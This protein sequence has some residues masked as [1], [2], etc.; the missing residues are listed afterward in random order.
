MRSTCSSAKRV[1]WSVDG[2]N[3]NP[4]PRSEFASCPGTVNTLPAASQQQHPSAESG[5]TALSEQPCALGSHAPGQ[6]ADAACLDSLVPC[7]Q[8]GLRHRLTEPGSRSINSTEPHVGHI[9][10][11]G[12]MPGRQQPRPSAALTAAAV[13]SAPA[14]LILSLLSLDNSVPSIDIRVFGSQQPTFHS[15]ASRASHNTTMPAAHVAVPAIAAAAAAAVAI[16]E[17]PWTQ[18]TARALRR[19]Q[20]EVKE[21]FAAQGLPPSAEKPMCFDLVGTRAAG[22]GSAMPANAHVRHDWPVVEG[23][24]S[25]RKSTPMSSSSGSGNDGQLSS[26]GAGYSSDGTAAGLS[27]GH[28]IAGL[29]HQGTSNGLSGLTGDSLSGCPTPGTPASP[30]AQ[31]LWELQQRRGQFGTAAGVQA[32]VR[33]SSRGGQQVSVAGEHTGAKQHQVCRVPS[34]IQQSK[35]PW[36]DLFT[37]HH[38]AKQSPQ[39]P[40]HLAGTWCSTPTHSSR[41]AGQLAKHASKRAAEGSTREVQLDAALMARAEHSIALHSLL[42]GNSEPA[43]GCCCS[44]VQTSSS[45][46]GHCSSCW[47]LSSSGNSHPQ[48]RRPQ[49][50]PAGLLRN[51]SIQPAAGSSAAKLKADYELPDRWWTVG[52]RPLNDPL[53]LAMPVWM[54]DALDLELMPL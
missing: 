52:D 23:I 24:L 3:H 49:T 32:A 1:T 42:A 34:R 12:I 51:C 7:A 2:G 21:L 35:E 50:A 25:A 38:L 41:K 4:G 8:G 6:L 45:A 27:T 19:V 30:A 47:C 53:L 28:I 15:A 39:T 16:S 31:L 9:T 29:Q 13:G 11:Q 17:A 20:Q 10:A 43:P 33:P 5:L 18:N 26:S 37:R 46:S 54:R 40:V 14:D 48:S 36:D 22:T 44:S